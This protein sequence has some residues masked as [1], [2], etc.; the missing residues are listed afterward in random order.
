LAR[1]VTVINGRAVDPSTGSAI[2]YRPGETSAS[3]PTS[4]TQINKDVFGGGASPAFQE[5]LQE[6]LT[7]NIPKDA[8]TG[9][10]INPQ[11]E[12]EKTGWLQDLRTWW[13]QETTQMTP[14]E[15]EQNRADNLATASKTAIATAGVAAVMTIPG[16]VYNYLGGKTINTVAY[17]TPFEAGK[18]LSYKEINYLAY[19]EFGAQNTVVNPKTLGL[20]GGVISTKAPWIVG[21]IIAG[22][23]LIGAT[24]WGMYAGSEAPESPN[25]NMRDIIQ[26]AYDTDDWTTF[27]QYSKDLD[28][29]Y[30][31][32]NP[33]KLKN[34][35]PG[36]GIGMESI[37]KFEGNLLGWNILKAHAEDL[38]SGLS[39]DQVWAKR[40]A[41]QEAS[42]KKITET[43]LK[44]EET[45]RAQSI[46]DFAEA[47][48]LKNVENNRAAARAMEEQ[49]LFWAEYA[50]KQRELEKIAMEEQAKFWLAYWKEKLK[51]QS[52]G[53][54][55]RLNF[56]FL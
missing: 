53:G 22:A 5:K 51:M 27:D 40:R 26:S 55:S 37:N 33:S 54:R 35:L 13:K 41:E 52:E 32:A 16:L 28:N 49:A 24:V 12:N 38:R 56:A 11:Q 43:R 8:L 34:E 14:A 42:S 25:I 2:G 1:K 29:L 6:A 30:E 46:A 44:L 21:G 45:A 19:G 50:D 9:Q 10:S 20:I 3:T 48:R 36:Y 39:A 31:A 18:T 47:N 4:A 7:P 15:I 17:K 23:S